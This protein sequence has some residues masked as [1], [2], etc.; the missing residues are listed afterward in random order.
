MC[1]LKCVLVCS[2]R[3]PQP[4]LPDTTRGSRTEILGRFNVG[5]LNVVG[6]NGIGLV[7]LTETLILFDGPVIVVHV[8]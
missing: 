5:D 1:L 3:Q 7:D 6:L 2:E 8:G 4:V